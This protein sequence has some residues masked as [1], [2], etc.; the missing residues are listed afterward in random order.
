MKRL[1]LTHVITPAQLAKRASAMGRCLRH[2]AL[3]DV[4]TLAGLVT[5]MCVGR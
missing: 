3:I 5:T 2:R 4:L 1:S